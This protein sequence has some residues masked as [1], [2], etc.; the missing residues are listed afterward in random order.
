[1]S[2]KLSFLSLLL[3][4]LVVP[5]T[6]G[7]TFA[8][9]PAAVLARKA[10]SENVAESAPAIEELRDLGPAGLDSLMAAYA[11]EIKH[12]ISNPTASSSDWQRINK[13]L[14]TV[15]QQKNSY[16][17]GLFWYTD[18]NEARK[19]AKQSGKPILSLRLLGKLTEELSCAN[20]RY[21]RTVLYPDAEVS[22]MLRDRFILHWQSVRPAPVITVDF[23]DGR[24]IE[25]TVTGNSIHYV[26]DSEG[27]LIEALPGLYGPKAFLRGLT[28]VEVLAQSL[29]GKDQENYRHVLYD[30][31]HKRMNEISASWMK[32]TTRI[33][34]TLP[35][36]FRLV[37]GNNGEAIA[38]MPLAMTKAFSENSL[39]RAMTAGAE[40]LGHIT[41]GE[42]W[43]KIA[44]LHADDAVL[45]ERSKSLIKR[46]S[47]SLTEVEMTRLLQRFESLI[48]LDTVRN[49]YLLHTKLYPWLMREPSRL[50]LNKFNEQVYAQLFLTPGSDPWLG[51]LTPDAYTAIENGGVVKKDN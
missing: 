17:S 47:P 51:L 39:L 49:E 43:K 3:L 4:V 27:R 20:S 48:A 30:Y 5:Q 31:Y 35:R 9:E 6:N 7:T 46:Q 22:A 34:G 33:G 32:D 44:Q 1:M 25:R 40:E 42:A 10:V 13:A 12:H 37:E 28:A 23:G 19:A 38:I 45:D 2:S 29:K 11:S 41:D 50:D 16:L 8:N 24:K 36:G 15:S 26:L 21:F 14:D 18:L